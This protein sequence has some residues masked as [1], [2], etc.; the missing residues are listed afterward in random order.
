MLNI[1]LVGAGSL[2]RYVASILS[3]ER[4]NVLVLDKDPSVLSEISSTLD[5]AT[6]QGSATDWQLLDELLE[7]SPDCL[8]A[9]TSEDEVNLVC[10]SIAKYLQYPRTIARIKEERFLNRMRLD[11]GHIFHVD[12]FIAPELLVAYDLLK[13]IEEPNAKYIEYFAHGA[14]ELKTFKIPADW[15]NKG[16]SLKQ[17]NLPTNII[18]CLIV[19]EIQ[20]EMGEKTQQVI[21]PHGNDLIQPNDEVT[22]VGATE[23]I[24]QIHRLFNI[25]Q[26]KINSV[27]IAGGSLTAIFLAELLTH[28]DIEV[29]I[30]EKDFKTCTQLADRLPECTIIHHDAKDLSFFRSE[31]IGQN[32]LFISAVG[33]DGD[34]LLISLLAKEAGCEEIVMVVNHPEYV[35]VVEKYGINHTSAS[36]IVTSNHILSQLR[37]KHISSLVTFYDDQAEIIEITVSQSS[38]IIGIPISDLGPY[39]PSDFLIVMIENRGRIMIAHGNRVISPGDTVIVVTSPK[40]IQELEKIF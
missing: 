24:E 9:L 20:N 28:R 33:E 4:Y 8:V 40:H 31:K 36:R 32:D 3:R 25:T 13:Q 11:F 12:T 29:C 14:L 30:I 7:F 18:V 5:V 39:L 1:L 37:S 34:N 23:A 21:F 16:L 10:C 17:F 22:F 15:Q 27:A 26:K 38:P 2:G 6:R 19:R 35:S